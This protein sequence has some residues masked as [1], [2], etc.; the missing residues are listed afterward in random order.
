METF[1]AVVENYER[2]LKNNDTNLEVGQQL[3][4]FVTNLRSSKPELADVHW[5]YV[6]KYV[7]KYNRCLR[8]NASSVGALL[9]LASE[10][11]TL[12]SAMFTRQLLV[13]DARISTLFAALF[14]KIASQTAHAALQ[15][16]DLDMKNAYL[17]LYALTYGCNEM[18]SLLKTLAYFIKGNFTAIG[19][20]TEVIKFDPQ[21]IIDRAT[22]ITNLLIETVSRCVELD[23]TGHRLIRS[24]VFPHLHSGLTN[25]ATLSASLQLLRALVN[26]ANL[27][28]LPSIKSLMQ[29]LLSMLPS[30][31]N[32]DVFWTLEFVSLKLGASSTLYRAIDVI[33]QAAKNQNFSLASCSLLASVIRTASGLSETQQLENVCSEVCSR[34]LADPDYEGFHRLLVALLSQT[35]EHLQIP[36]NVARTVV[37]RCHNDESSVLYELKAL[38]SVMCRPKLMDFASPT[39][40]RK[41]RARQQQIEDDLEILLDQETETIGSTGGVEEIQQEQEKMQTEEPEQRPESSTAYETKLQEQDDQNPVR[42]RQRHISGDDD[43]ILI[44]DSPK[45]AAAGFVNLTETIGSNLPNSKKTPRKASEV[46]VMPPSNPSNRSNS[47]KSSSKSPTSKIPASPQVKL[48]KPTENQQNQHPQTQKSHPTADEIVDLLEL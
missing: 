36:I 33:L 27:F 21:L 18:K 22:E 1:G 26:K 6:T 29:V 24:D 43:E 30:C 31:E 44:L 38:T 17:D 40:F 9:K 28:I 15:N 42:K 41:R 20:D 45:R 3:K 14:D 13:S 10:R 5:I 12:A 8:E 4:N 7:K 34:C 19:K 47:W 32:D 37:E 16:Y 23:Q 35:N 25:S 39:I 48:Q 46:V 2:H 11:C